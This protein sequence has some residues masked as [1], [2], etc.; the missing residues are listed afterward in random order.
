M[1]PI[2]DQSYRRYVGVR[3]APGSAWLTIATTG[4]RTVLGKKL[5]L[6]FIKNK[7]NNII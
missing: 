5:F 6:D 7:M 3:Q 1:T 4:I 2:H